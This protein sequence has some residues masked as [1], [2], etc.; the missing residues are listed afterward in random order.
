MPK[1]GIYD[2]KNPVECAIC[3]LKWLH[4]YLVQMIMLLMLVVTLI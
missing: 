2:Y 4:D 1:C 3:D